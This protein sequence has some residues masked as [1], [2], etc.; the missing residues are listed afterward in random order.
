MS[1][2]KGNRNEHRSINLLKSCGYYVIRAAASLGEFDLIAMDAFS[3]RLI[4]VKTN[5]WPG[6]E[7]R[8]AMLMVPRPDNAT[9]EAWRWNDYERKPH[10][11]VLG[12]CQSND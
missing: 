7:E 6:P 11:R 4:Q 1:K 9:V 5:R 8:T 3:F 2:R 12:S 10:I